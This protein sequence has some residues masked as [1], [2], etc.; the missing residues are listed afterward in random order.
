M[1]T[2]LQ[3]KGNSQLVKN[4]CSAECTSS[5]KPS[6][7]E[8]FPWTHQLLLQILP[9]LSDTL[10]PLYRVLQK[11]VPWRWDKEQQDAFDYTKSQLTTDRVL[12]HYDS[13]KS[14]VLAGDASPYGLGAVLSHKLDNGEE[15][16]IAFASRSLAPAEKQYSQLKIETL[17]SCLG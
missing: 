4:Q 12:V 9:N 3:K 10:S 1:D 16:P 13:A 8:V 7:M 11:R 2:V 17:Q 6:T 14:I 15:K 5:H